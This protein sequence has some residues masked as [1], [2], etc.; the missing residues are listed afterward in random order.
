MRR[1]LAADLAAAGARVVMT[2][3]ARLPEEPGPWEVIRLGPGEAFGSLRRLAHRADHTILIAPETAGIL[4]EL[5]RSVIEAG[6]RPIGGHPDAIGLA[7]DKLRLSDHLARSGVA[8]PPGQLIRPKA[9]LPTEFP[10]PAVLKP[11]DGAGSLD[12][13]LVASP[14]DPIVGSFTHDEGLLQPFVVGE[15]RSA[16][17]LGRPGLPALLLGV[18]RQEIRLEGGRFS[19]KGGTVLTETLPATHPGRRAAD[20]APGLSGLF[21]V[22]YIHDPVTASAQVL[23]INPRP[24]P[25]LVGLVAALGPGRLGSAWLATLMGEHPTITVPTRSVSFRS[26]GTILRHE[27]S[28]TGTRR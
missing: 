18:G 26:D 22:D 23:E 3:D 6:G 5:T 15:P 19:Y 25:S 16:T 10:Y 7:A 9:Q 8:T 20:S 17:F 4:Q 2:L 28:T 11:V 1:A 21:G 13:L 24:T 27:V 14:D 12:T